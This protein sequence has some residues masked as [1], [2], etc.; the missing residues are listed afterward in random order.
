[1]AGQWNWNGTIIIT[2]TSNLMP[3]GRLAKHFDK[4]FNSMNALLLVN[5]FSSLSAGHFNF[6]TIFTLTMRFGTT[7]MI[8]RNLYVSYR[9][10]VPDGQWRTHTWKHWKIVEEIFHHKKYIKINICFFRFLSAMPSYCMRSFLYTQSFVQAL[11]YFGSVWA[12]QTY[13]IRMSM[14]RFRNYQ[15][16]LSRWLFATHRTPFSVFYILLFGVLFLQIKRHW[17]EGK[18][19]CARTIGQRRNAN[20]HQHRKL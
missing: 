10:I 4:Y 13:N 15:F 9:F 1:M 2:F 18:L 5:C 16:G 11:L 12:K 14:C 3:I 7:W 6:C 8:F 17:M 19:I 20:G